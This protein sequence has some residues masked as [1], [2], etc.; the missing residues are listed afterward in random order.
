ML[1]T[2]G[3]D[4]YLLTPGPLTTSLETKKAMLRDW[5]S[6]DEQFISLTRKICRRLVD[7]VDG[8]GTHACV[9]V[10]GSGTFAVEAALGTLIG[11][12]DKALL[13]VNGTYGRRMAQILDIIG[14]DHIILETP[15]NV[16]CNVALLEQTLSQ[17]PDITHVA[18]VHCETTSGIVNPIEDISAVVQ[19]YGRRLLIDAM[20]AFGA[21][22]LSTHNVCFDAVMA[23][24]NKCLEG[25]PGFGFV[26]AKET[27]LHE[28]EGNAHS[29]SLDL[30][31][32]WQ[33]FNKNGQWRF[34][35]PTHVCAAFA[36]ALREYDA[37]G[38]L[39]ARH[40][41]YE[42]NCRTLVDGMEQMGFVPFLDR[43]VQAP[44]IVTFHS[45]ADPKFDFYSF[46]QYL[47]ERH[48]VIYPGK[49][50]TTASFRIG[51]IGQVYEEHIK[52]ALAAIRDYLSI[53]GV[54][55]CRPVT[56]PRKDATS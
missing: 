26:I 2:T 27:S 32:Q 38:G 37:E 45:P 47:A 5:G 30:Y 12:S 16:P 8:L 17:D 34:T 10:Q 23:S 9:P 40:Q 36:Q 46:F 20:S 41:R 18:V 51:C 14:R 33:G 52:G 50:T 15:E 13:L 49:L 25:V 42:K 1:N 7:L 43:A 4:H 54:T 6:R 44:I 35:P 22:A 31:A 39:V 53:A 3:N 55:D 11:P 48:Y 56:P 21:L 29:L 24:S 19:E 28:A